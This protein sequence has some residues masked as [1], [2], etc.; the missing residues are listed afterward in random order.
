V[1]VISSQVHTPAGQPVTKYSFSGDVSFD[2]AAQVARDIVSKVPR[3]VMCVV[4]RG[5]AHGR[6]M[7]DIIQNLLQFVPESSRPE[8]VAV[9]DLN[10]SAKLLS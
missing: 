7:V 5:C 8:R 4:E 6:N 3:M 1:P 2:D 10:S 9:L